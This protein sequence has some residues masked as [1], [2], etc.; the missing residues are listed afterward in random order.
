MT[1]ARAGAGR[2]AVTVASVDATDVRRKSLSL[3]APGGFILDQLPE[4]KYLLS[5][6]RD[7][8]DSGTYSYGLPFPFKPAERFA[9]YQDSVKV[10]ARWGVEGVVIP[11]K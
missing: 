7:A 5:A 8:D 3:P 4:G 6:F 2:I 1:D 11:L 9:V 10:R